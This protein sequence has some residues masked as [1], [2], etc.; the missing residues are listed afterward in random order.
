MKVNFS[1]DNNCYYLFILFILLLLIIIVI[2]FILTALATIR[3]LLLWF[4]FSYNYTVT[5]MVTYATLVTMVM[6]QLQLYNC[7][8][9]YLSATVIEIHIIVSKAVILFLCIFNGK[10]FH[11]L[12]A[13]ASFLSMYLQLLV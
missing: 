12:V 6:L 9:G 3:Q 11:R 8:Y 13:Y 5:T 4:P 2:L 7:Y 10:H 1:F